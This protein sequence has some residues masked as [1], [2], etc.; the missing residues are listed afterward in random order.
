MRIVRMLLRM[1]ELML[2]GV[3]S[4]GFMLAQTNAPTHQETNAAEGSIRLDVAVTDVQGR[5]VTGLQAKDFMLLDDDQPTALVSFHAWDRTQDAPTEVILVI[6]RVNLEPVQVT[7]ANREVERFLRANDGHLPQ[8]VMIYWLTTDGL[9][10]SEQPSIDGNQ[11]ATEV[12]HGDGPDMVWQERH[13]NPGA[14]PGGKWVFGFSLTALG[15][16]TIEARRRPGRKLLLWIGPGWPVKNEGKVTLAEIMERMTRMCEARIE[17]SS[18][19]VWPYPKSEF[20][21]ED[22]LEPPPV[23]KDG[24]SYNLMVQVQAKQSGG[25]VMNAAS[26]LE[27]AIEQTIQGANDFYTM[28]FDPPRAKGVDEYHALKVKVD[29]PDATVRTR[30]G[31]FDEPVFYDQPP[32]L[33][34][35]TLAQFEK[36]LAQSRKVSDN[37]LARQLNGLELTERMSIAELARWTAQMPGTKSRATLVMLADRSTFEAPPA[38]SIVK[39]AQPDVTMQKQMLART[40]DYLA[41]ALGKL[42]DLY[43][44]RTTVRYEET[45]Q[46]GEETWKTTAGDQSLHQA[47]MTKATVLIRNGKESVDANAKKPKSGHKRARDLVEEGTF[48]PILATVVVGAAAPGSRM[49]WSRWEQGVNGMEAVFR[50]SVPRET[51]L[52]DVAFCYEADPDGTVVFQHKTGFDGEI[53]ID[54]K[55][56]AV[57]RIAVHAN[58]VPRLPIDL[59]GI[60]VE[61]GPVQIGGMT[62][63]CPL[64][65]VSI[66]RSRAVRLINEWKESFG[67]YGPFETM[68]NDVV[69]TDYHVFR[70]TARILPSADSTP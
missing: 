69:F 56:G 21:Y 66:S 8:P 35:V 62:Y 42:P 49:V 50:L 10:R 17:L 34:R 18:V 37:E 67:V 65:S 33:A 57:M 7:A 52:F 44:T 2:L 55:S 25:R 6:D 22:N 26:V 14:L 31:Y 51:P 3:V 19:T 60:A 61:Y 46:K 41:R 9:T 53:A 68:V 45:A 4:C 43:A 58:L 23:G 63:I 27:N 1:W 12:E 64:H 24:V 48:G 54:P 16:I 47:G 29:R 59:A 36:T 38:S 13:R 20:A 70:S 39:D 28:T 5:P 40:V 32:E 30:T 11:L 15:S